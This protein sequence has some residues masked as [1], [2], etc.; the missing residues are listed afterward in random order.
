MNAQTRATDHRATAYAYD[1]MAHN[2]A[3]RN[4]IRSYDRLAL[5]TIAQWAAIT[6]SGLTVEFFTGEARYASSADLFTDL[7]KGHLWSLLTDVSRLAHDHPM[8][9]PLPSLVP[10]HPYLVLNDVFRAVHDVNGHGISKGSFGVNGEMKAWQTHREMY[11]PTAHAALWCETRGQAAWTN[12][13]GD[14]AA[15]PLPQRPFAVQKA[16]MPPI[17]FI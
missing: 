4:V 15:L 6:A 11:S 2:P 10:A 3:D 5:E 1:A 16:G 9:A 8:L 12:A 13:Y 7:A 17:E 14:H